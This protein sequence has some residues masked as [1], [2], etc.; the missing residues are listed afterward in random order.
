[1]AM[2]DGGA[3][4]DHLAAGARDEHQVVGLGQIGGEAA[5]IDRRVEHVVGDAIGQRGVVRGQARDLDLHA[6][7]RFR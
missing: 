7:R 3:L 5:R 1:M 2:D 6:K 4:A